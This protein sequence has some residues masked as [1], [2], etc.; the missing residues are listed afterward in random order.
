MKEIGGFF[1]LELPR[2]KEYHSK[3]IRL[4]TGR[5]SLEYILKN[6]NYKKIYIPFYICNSIL[7]PIKKLNIE[8]EQYYINSNFDIELDLSNIKENELVLYVNYFGIC[9]ENV[10]KLLKY[11]Q[12]Y[13]FDVCIDNT[14]AFFNMP[15]TEEHT[16]YSVRKFFGVEDGAYLYSNK[17][18][19]LGLETEISY[20]KSTY[21]LKRID[22]GASNS[23]VDFKESSKN[24]SNQPIRYMS[25]LSKRILESIDYELVSKKRME[26]FTLLKDNLSSL[27]RL[28]I[29]LENIICT[30]V[31]PLL[32]E[33][34]K[35][36]RAKLI[37]NNIFIA[38]YWPSI[39]QNVNKDSFESNIIENLI[40]IPIDQRYDV[41]DMK[42]ILKVIEE[43]SHD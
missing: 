2:R 24:H 35:E 39:L 10:N 3:A 28:E 8:Y 13:L 9:N 38:Q 20:D 43:I 27:N 16:I 7:E 6:N 42:Y 26:N 18:T 21:L 1:E 41:S 5:N 17:V 33:N 22:L 14:Q 32:V 30:M 34:G 12:E 40:P 4:N 19:D 23:Y 31:Y 11:K 25:N 29:N 37:S 15:M 36:L